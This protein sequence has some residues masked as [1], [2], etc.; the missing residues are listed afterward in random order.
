MRGRVGWGWEDQRR[1]L[2][3]G[4]RVARGVM[5]G[6]Q[7]CERWCALRGY[8]REWGRQ[9]P[10]MG[11]REEADGGWGARARKGSWAL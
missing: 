2:E 9:Q 8:V 4:W 7:K 11:V 5:E 6:Q 3:G 10:E 1:D